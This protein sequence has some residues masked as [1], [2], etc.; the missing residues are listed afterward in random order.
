MAKYLNE[1]LTIFGLCLSVLCLF[2]LYILIFKLD[3]YKNFNRKHWWM[4]LFVGQTESRST[5]ITMAALFFIMGLA[6]IDKEIGLFSKYVWGG[7]LFIAM[8]FLYGALARYYWRKYKQN[9]NKQ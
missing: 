4:R 1:H 2:D 7:L 9:K 6:L 8:I 5:G 3:E